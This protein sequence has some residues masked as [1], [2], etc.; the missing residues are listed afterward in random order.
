[1]ADLIVSVFRGCYEKASEFDLPVAFSEEYKDWYPTYEG[2]LV[3][4]RGYEPEWL[5]SD[6]AT[7][8][9]AITTGL[10]GNIINMFELVTG[11]SETTAPNE[12]I[13]YLCQTD[14]GLGKIYYFDESVPTWTR[15]DCGAT[16]TTTTALTD[17]R[18]AN[19]VVQKCRF[20][21]ENGVVRVLAGNRSVNQP[22]WWGY[23]GARFP[24]AISDNSGTKAPISGGFLSTAQRAKIESPVMPTI[25]DHTGIPE[26]TG[27]TW[28]SALELKATGNWQYRYYRYRMALQYD[29]KQWSPPSPADGD[30]LA[31]LSTLNDNY[32]TRTSLLVEIDSSIISR[33]VTGFA[34]FRSDE[35]TGAAMGRR[36]YGTF[37]LLTY[38]TFSDNWGKIIKSSGI[39]LSIAERLIWPYTS[40]WIF[41][42]YTDATKTFAIGSTEAGDDALADDMLNGGM[43]IAWH[44]TS[45]TFYYCL[46]ADTDFTAVD[47][48]SIV[49]DTALGEN[50][51]ETFVIQAVSGWYEDS[52]TYKYLFLDDVP[53]EVMDYS[54]TMNDFLGISQD[55]Y[56]VMYPK[57][58]TTIQGQAFYANGYHLDEQKEHLISYGMLTNSGLFANDTHLT[59]NVFTCGVPIKGL[60]SIADRLIVFADT[61]IF[62]GII[63]NANEASWDFEKLFDQF[64]LM[65]EESLVSISGRLLFL[66]SDWDVKMFDGTQR[67]KSIGGGIYDVLRD[68]GDASIDYLKNAIGFQM[69][70]HNMYVLRIQTGATSYEYWAYP[71]DGDVGWIQIRW[72]DTFTGFFSTSTGETFAFK[73]DDLMRLNKGT[74]DDGTAINPEWKSLPLSLDKKLIHHFEQMVAVYKSNTAIQ[75]QIYLDGSV[76]A[77]GTVSLDSQTLLKAVSKNVP[78]STMARTIQLKFNIPLANRAS[79]TQ[80]E[81]DEVI[82]PVEKTSGGHV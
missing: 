6:E 34:I 38:A 50:D 68:A 15:L 44:P 22:L 24:N 49:I 79:N 9:A 80:C 16:D 67:P 47:D 30:M 20:M 35:L 59:R 70:K 51:G 61:G 40:Q 39:S 23:C 72:A 65:A 42:T 3:K 37:R 12:A 52:G 53:K 25:I 76:S 63:P 36:E 10:A 55:D 33:R 57:Y 62:I 48:Q 56:T 78:L 5:D 77:H 75:C 58:G 19:S 66:A 54:V 60:A 71:L 13:K 27:V 74:D 31:A 8:T 64:G 7:T 41:A 82:L 29:H 69:P 4:R 17:F 1:M 73:A 81:I 43:L 28:N 45:N 26:P 46:I 18:D 21:A 11:R 14:D 32:R 2:K